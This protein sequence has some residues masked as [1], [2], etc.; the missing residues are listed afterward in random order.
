MILQWLWAFEIVSL[1][2]IRERESIHEI[3]AC[4]QNAEWRI[5]W[6]NV[7]TRKWRS[8]HAHAGMARKS[9]IVSLNDPLL[10]GFLRNW[11]FSVSK[12]YETKVIDENFYRSIKIWM[13]NQIVE[14]D[15]PENRSHIAVRQFGILYQ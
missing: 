12:F 7:L 9:I 1:E 2:S 10:F 4:S 3:N 5:V 11:N 14:R 8:S 6:Y 13:Q 15:I